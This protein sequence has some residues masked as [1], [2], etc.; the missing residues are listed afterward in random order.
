[1]NVRETQVLVIG[2][3][4]SG[5]CVAI[6]LASTGM[7]F[8]ILERAADVGG[9]WRNNTY[10]GCSV[11]VAAHKYSF[12]FALNPN[13]S[14]RRPGQPEILSYLRSIV[15]SSGLHERI[16]YREDAISASYDTTMGLWRVVTASGRLYSSWAVVL[17]TGALQQP[18]IPELEGLSL[19]RGDQF[20]SAQWPQGLDL[21]GKRVA[22]IGTGAS[23]I[24]FI[25]RI[26][27]IVEKLFVFQRTPPWIIPRWDRDVGER[28][29][30]L[31][32]RF[33]VLMRLYRWLLFWQAEV[34]AVAFVRY[35][36]L[37][38][39]AEVLALRHMKRSISDSV[40]RGLLTPNYRLGCKRI[41]RSD[42]Y[43][44]AVAVE[45]VEVVTSEIS[46]V[47][48]RAIWTADGEVR[49]VD[50]IIFGT[51]FHV[52]D[53]FTGVRIAGLKALTLAEAWHG[54]MEAHLGVSVTGF[55]NLFLMV[56][57]NSGVGHN[58]LVFMIELQAKYI[59]RLLKRAHLT[60]GA[61]MVTPT[62]F[63][64]YNTALQRRLQRTVWARGRCQSWY[65]D[66]RGVNRAL[67]P[68]TIVSYWLRTLTARMR[69]YVSLGGAGGQGPLT[70]GRGR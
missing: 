63:R 24:Q 45:N 18:N 57:P 23:A 51:G 33:P 34:T 29:K 6:R 2:A 9:T 11:D 50:V 8:L 42:D 61:L 38:R 53:A 58:S 40:L 55:P 5:I 67:W 44:A 16:V 69:D 22:V 36:S 12:S 39:I 31:F 35:L 43:Y 70:G 49:G 10:P 48:E 3:G 46:R 26:Q 47:D 54:G 41:L 37:L 62:V 25:P 30:N 56:G 1:M 4:F 21:R 20:H 52:A 27:P 14:A 17:A 7:D 66:D 32:R 28:A 15:E 65:L 64:K 59:A 13:W 19:F 68:G 60:D